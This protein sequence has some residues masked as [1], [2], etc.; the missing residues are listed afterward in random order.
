M[1]IAVMG[2][3]ALGCYFGGRLARSG[4]DIAF[5]ARGAQLKALRRDGLRIE[6]PLGDD[7]IAPVTA[8]DDP[9]EIG[10]VDTILFLVKLYDTEAAARRIAPMLGAETAVVSFQNGIDPWDRI[11]VVV[12]PGHVV[13][14]TAVIPADIR[15][16]GIVRHNGPFARLTFGE[17]DGR[18]SA[19]CEA[20]CAAL[21]HAGV[22]AEVVPDIEVKIWEK[23][24][25]LSALAAATALTRLS[26]G[27]ILADPL[28]RDLFRAA[29][30]ESHAVGRA[31]CPALGEDAADRAFA[32]AS[33]FP[34]GM[35][36]SMLD[37]LERGKRLELDGLSGAVVRLGREHDI[38]TPTHAVVQAALHP[39]VDGA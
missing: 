17:F 38:E 13:G 21:E 10:P 26:I 1:K 37:D 30:R 19:R 34:P 16:P 9:E 4:A 11:A 22:E 7:H 32:L 27:P 29:I 8:T 12:G 24:L 33:D 14:G 6:S 39:Y 3:G 36:A 18:K 31:A 35:R 25:V 5:V 15:A 2:A 28:G 23:F 20:L